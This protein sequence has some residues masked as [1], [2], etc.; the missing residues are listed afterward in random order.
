MKKV[1]YTKLRAKTCHKVYV[2]QTC[3]NLK[4]RFWEH[5]RYIK[6]NDPRSAYAL[7]ILN[8]R[9]ECGNIDDTMTRLK[10][11]NTPTLLLPYGQMYSHS[12]HRNNELLPEQ[13]GHRSAPMSVHCTESCIYSQK[14]LRRMG[15]FVARNMY[16]IF[17]QINKNIDKRNLLHHVGCLH[18]C[19]E[20][21]FVFLTNTIFHLYMKG[22]ILKSFISLL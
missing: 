1:E 12:F 5:T 15:E 10:Q 21:N 4:S 19:H 2:G 17:K 8:C 7:H 6:N 13:Q 9:H 14:V 11:I 16:S 20:I 22:Y 3:R 18:R